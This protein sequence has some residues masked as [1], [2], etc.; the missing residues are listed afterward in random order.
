MKNKY[1]ILG[2][3]IAGIGAQY[4]LGKEANIYE[5]RDRVGG[6]CDSFNINGFTFDNAVHL[7]FAKYTFL[8][9]QWQSFYHHE[10][11]FHHPNLSESSFPFP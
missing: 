6:L 9:A 1:V 2:G 10:E 5:A 8:P 4:R 11:R 3:G 7:S